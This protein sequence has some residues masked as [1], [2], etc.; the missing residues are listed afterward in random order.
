M[1]TEHKVHGAGLQ[2]H[3]VIIT[4]K[5]PKRRLDEIN[6]LR[7]RRSSGNASANLACRRRH[8]AL[9]AANTMSTLSH[10]P[11]K[12]QHFRRREEAS[13]EQSRRNL[14]LEAAWCAALVAPAA[15][16]CLRG[17][18][19]RGWEA[20]QAERPQPLPAP[21]PERWLGPGSAPS[22]EGSGAG[23]EEARRRGRS[24]AAAAAAV[25]PVRWRLRR[26][27]NAAAAEDCAIGTPD[28]SGLGWRQV[29]RAWRGS[30]AAGR[31]TAAETGGA[32]G[33]RSGG[34]AAERVGTTN[35]WRVWVGLV[36]M[37]RNFGPLG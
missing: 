25:G 16:C 2:S 36:W 30:N 8:R 34:R 10:S 26:R 32:A 27:S 35:R 17:D 15:A 6:Y 18:R 14:Y 29:Q 20:G 13:E 24:A 37:G 31:S 22:E 7:L 1:S 21:S 19:E 4:F 23:S 12:G 33:G 5:L 28:V 9:G 3:N 11:K